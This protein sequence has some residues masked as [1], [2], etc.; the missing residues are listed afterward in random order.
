MT[1]L[2]GAG[3]AG[4]PTHIKLKSRPEILI[5]NAA[6]CE[7]LLHKDK[8]ILSLYTDQVLDGMRMAMDMTGAMKGIIG[9]KAKQKALIS[10]LDKRLNGKIRLEPVG[11]FYPAGDE[12]TLVHLTT[13]RIVPPGALPVQAGCLVQNVETLYN[14]ASGTPVTEKWLTVAG[15]VEK[16]ATIKVPVGI[17]IRDV[18]SHFRITA[19]PAIVRSGGLMMGKVEPDLDAPVTKTTNGLIVLPAGHSL[20]GIYQ[21]YSDSGATVRTA[22][23]SC[24]QCSFCTELCPRYLL[25][26]PV[27]PETAMRNLLFGRNQVE[28]VHPGNAFCCEC[29]LCTLYACPEGLDPKN[30]TVMEKRITRKKEVTEARPAKP[31]PMLPYRKVPI[32][33]LKQR[34]GVSGFPDQGP[35]ESI[36]WRPER[37][38]IPLLQH[39]GKPAVPCVK[40]GDRVQRGQMIGRPDGDASSAVHASINGLVSKVTEREIM[41][42]R[43]T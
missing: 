24:D 8:E 29:N 20:S 35:F 43:Q 41:L 4:F 10:E 11:D 40:E 28:T 18:L 26:Y 13:G 6:E 5:L 9:I 2:V 17:L 30:A 12:V 14:L 15:A 33:R 31:H 1:G 38:C 22:M 37:V 36:E 23:A 34:L 32:S 27:R 25:G 16:P 39:I 7:P 19:S 3:G 42:L 21:R